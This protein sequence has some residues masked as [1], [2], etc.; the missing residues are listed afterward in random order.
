MTGR[1]ERNWKAGT[2]VRVEA[3]GYGIHGRAG[4][5]EFDTGN[6]AG[7]LSVRLDNGKRAALATNE[8]VQF[9]DEQGRFA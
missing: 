3:P 6:A 5:V 7:L 4:T 2:R 1:C 9:R 8:A